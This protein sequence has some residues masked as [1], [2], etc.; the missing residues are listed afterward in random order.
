MEPNSTVLAD[1]LI[2]SLVGRCAGVCYNK[3]IDA[4]A[5]SS[6]CEYAV[7]LLDDFAQ[8]LHDERSGHVQR[9][10]QSFVRA[11]E[12]VLA[13]SS[14]IRSRRAHETAPDRSGALFE[15]F[16]KVTAECRCCWR[17]RLADEGAKLHC[18]LGQHR[19]PRSVT[20][21]GRSAGP[22]AWYHSE[23]DS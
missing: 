8:Y 21:K 5:N 13:E 20:K 16:S 4:Q 12:P 11:P 9:E 14:V 22:A 3:H 15:G 10:A 23:L 2:R 17:G 19:R 18:R 6:A 7:D 1:S